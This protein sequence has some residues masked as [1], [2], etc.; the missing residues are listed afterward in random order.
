MR[1]ELANPTVP[2]IIPKF[3]VLT[4]KQRLKVENH[5]KMMFFLVCRARTIIDLNSGTPHKKTWTF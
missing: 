3:K 5:Q 1:K 4:E 2:L